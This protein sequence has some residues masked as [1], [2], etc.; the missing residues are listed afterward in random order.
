MGQVL[1]EHTASLMALPGVVGTAQGL[2]DDEPCIRVFVVEA[3]EELLIQAERNVVAEIESSYKEFD[4][5]IDR[6]AATKLALEAALINYQAVFE[7]RKAGA[8]EP[9]ELLTA[10]VSLTTAESHYI[11]AYSATL[12][13]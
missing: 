6:L 1:R 5:N 10:Q 7:S 8:S 3:T 2:C 13:P 11:K 12:W 4:Q 9:L